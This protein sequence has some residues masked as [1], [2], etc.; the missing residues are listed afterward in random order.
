MSPI[1]VTFAVEVFV[2]LHGICVQH[3]ELHAGSYS[4]DCT[5][6]LELLKYVWIEFEIIVQNMPAF[7]GIQTDCEL[8]TK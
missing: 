4:S 7:S 5:Y 2:N 8:L 1:T 6:V 3:V